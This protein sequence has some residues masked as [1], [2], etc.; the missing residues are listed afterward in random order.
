MT[1]LDSGTEPNKKKPA[2][3]NVIPEHCEP[4]TTTTTT[5]GA[6]LVKPETNSRPPPLSPKPVSDQNT[7]T[8]VNKSPQ[9]VPKNPPTRPVPPVRLRPGSSSSN[10][11]GGIPD[12]GGTAMYAVVNKPKKLSTSSVGNGRTGSESSN[13]EQSMIENMIYEQ[14]QESESK[15][16]N[17]LTKPSQRQQNNPPDAHIYEECKSVSGNHYELA[18]AVTKPPL[19]AAAEYSYAEP[20][21]APKP[22]P[23]RSWGSTSSNEDSLY[24]TAGSGKKSHIF[25]MS[26]CFIYI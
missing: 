8:N 24:S 23:R 4:T 5:T 19:P 3:I 12:E 15:S 11:S 14:E 22:V 7:C 21:C 17:S 2:Y 16:R 20:A 18:R 1:L 10:A 9:T 13:N 26:V 25:G 6:S